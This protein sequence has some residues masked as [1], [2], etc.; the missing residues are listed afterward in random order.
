MPPIS[1]VA[2]LHRQSAA[3]AAVLATDDFAS[4]SRIGSEFRWESHCPVADDHPGVAVEA[5][6]GSG[7]GGSRGRPSIHVNGGVTRDWRTV[8]EQ[9]AGLILDGGTGGDVRNTLWTLGSLRR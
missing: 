3:E 9:I 4:A 8:V 7:D 1:R 2:G 5:C 6:R